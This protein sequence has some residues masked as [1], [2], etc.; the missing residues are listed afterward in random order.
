MTPGRPRTAIGTFGEITVTDLGGRHRAITRYR[1]LDGRLRRVMATG[2]SARVARAKLKEKLADRA[3][4][5]SGGLLSVA[6]QF[7]DLSDL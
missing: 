4:Y 2:P 6:S 1:D 3:G 7:G 5:G